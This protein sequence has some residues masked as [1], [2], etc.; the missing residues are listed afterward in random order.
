MWKNCMDWNCGHV[1]RVEWLVELFSVSLS[2]KYLARTIIYPHQ[3]SR[4]LWYSVDFGNQ[5][6]YDWWG[7]SLTS[8][9]QLS[10]HKCLY[11]IVY[12]TFARLFYLLHFYT[13]S[14]TCVPVD[15]FISI[16]LLW[17]FKKNTYELIK[18]IAKCPYFFLKC[19]CEK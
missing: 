5:L 9:I 12:F 11:I 17:L 3:Q 16:T 15:N 13:R 18:W 6:H 1:G 19:M 2:R 7:N 8:C 4:S 10:F 14:K